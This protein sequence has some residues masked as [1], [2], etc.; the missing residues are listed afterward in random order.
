MGRSRKPEDGDHLFSLSPGQGHRAFAWAQGSSVGAGRRP[1]TA[2]KTQPIRG[3]LP[4]TSSV[5]PTLQAPLTARSRCPPPNPGGAR[6]EEASGEDPPRDCPRPPCCA[7]N[8]LGT[9]PP[10]TLWPCFTLCPRAL[11]TPQLPD[12]SFPS[13]FSPNLPFALEP[14]WLLY[15]KR[16]PLNPLYSLP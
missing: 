4:E 1:Q 12:F 8:A 15:L 16:Q 11:C 13:R 10:P 3:A 14:S 9:L 7:H 6:P 5:S 2:A